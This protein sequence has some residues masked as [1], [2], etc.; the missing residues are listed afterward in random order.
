MLLSGFS[1]SS[2]QIDL[3]SVPPHLTFAE[4]ACQHSNLRYHN[5]N[6][7]YAPKSEH[8]LCHLK[9]PP[10]RNLEPSPLLCMVPSSP[11]IGK[12]TFPSAGTTLVAARCLDKAFVVDL[13]GIGP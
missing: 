12:C 2:L 3:P 5:V 1:T 4:P 13:V 11:L 9:S 10:E 6:A 8:K 7:T